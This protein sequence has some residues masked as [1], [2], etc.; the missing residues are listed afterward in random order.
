MQVPYSGYYQ[1]CTKIGFPKIVRLQY[2]TPPTI[3]SEI[4]LS[5]L[6]EVVVGIHHSLTV[7][8]ELFFGEKIAT[9]Y[10]N[11]LLI[12]KILSKL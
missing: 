5:P 4:C 2:L 10:I 12:K 7:F 11:K 3:V 6:T 9:L 8:V 1:L